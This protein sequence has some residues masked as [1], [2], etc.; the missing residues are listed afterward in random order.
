MKT[1]L[2]SK[3]KPLH[4]LRTGK[5]KALSSGWKHER[6][7]L[8]IDYELIVMTEGTLYLRYQDENFTVKEGEYLLL[9][10]STSF[11]EGFKE[12]YCSF[13]WMHF[14]ADPSSFPLCVTSDEQAQKYAEHAIRIP[15]TGSIPRPDKLV[16]QMKQLQDVVKNRYPQISLDV[17]AT[18]VMTE[19]FGELFLGAVSGQD[20]ADRKQIYLDIIDYIQTNIS[21]NIRISEIADAF[22]YNPK[23]LSHLFAELR[24]IPLKQFI[25]SQKVDAA[26][27]M[28]SDNDKAVTEIAAELGFS[29]VHNFARTYKK[30]T[31][32][33]PSE[34]RNAFAKRMLYH[35]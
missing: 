19:L 17:M 34:Y 8:D 29:D 21:R 6:F 20:P 7:P 9:P 23:Y 13:Y 10:P 18:C 24:G 3:E 31:G 27:F 2:F 22:G 12:S 30:I 14:A 1:M 11:R 16:V 32:L 33:T 25:L 15:Q 4:Y 28:L 5:F 26:N 35:V